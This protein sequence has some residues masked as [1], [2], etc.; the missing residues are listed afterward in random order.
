MA[1]KE[2]KLNKHI[3]KAVT[4]KNYT[5]PTAVQ[6][7]T[8][9]LVLEGNDVI[10]TAQTGTGKTAG[11][12]LPILQKLSSNIRVQPNQAR[13][14]ILTPTRELAIQ[15]TEVLEKIGRHLKV[16]TSSIFGG[17]EQDSQILKLE[18][19]FIVIGCK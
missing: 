7:Q 3:V 17:V 19:D 2:L 16:K 4:E 10:V 9:P 1:F 12:V 11:F 8:I 14:L 6:L 18:K 15:I 5:V 13:S